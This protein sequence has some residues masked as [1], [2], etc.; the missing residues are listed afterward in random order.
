[1]RAGKRAMRQECMR[2]ATVTAC[3]HIACMQQ[4]KAMLPQCFAYSLP[5]PPEHCCRQSSA[6]CLLSCWLNAAQQEQAQAAERATESASGCGSSVNGPPSP[7][8]V[9]ST[10]TALLTM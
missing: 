8:L 6:L 7:M 9:A 1:M 5:L 2:A 4:V 3:W 10:L